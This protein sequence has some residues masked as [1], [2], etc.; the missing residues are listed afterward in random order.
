M[1]QIPPTIL[2]NHRNIVAAARDVFKWRVR[3]RRI[4][5]RKNDLL[6][7]NR[8]VALYKTAIRTSNY[9]YVTSSHTFNS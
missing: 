4:Y 9:L 7:S 3:Y 6:R 8:M 2:Q 5:F 1:S